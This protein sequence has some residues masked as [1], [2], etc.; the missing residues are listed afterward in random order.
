MPYITKGKCVYKKDTGK[1]VGC[2]KGSVKKYLAALHANVNESEDL[3]WAQDLTSHPSIIDGLLSFKGK[4]V[5]IDISDLDGDQMKQLYD[6]LLPYVKVGGYDGP[7]LWWDNRCFK[8][9]TFRDSHTEVISL[10]CGIEDNG[11]KPVNGLVCCLPTMEDALGTLEEGDYI[12]IDG[13]MLLPPKNMNESEED[14]DWVPKLDPRE[15]VTFLP[16]IGTRVEV[17]T[18]DGVTGEKETIRGEVIGVYPE[19]SEEPGPFFTMMID[20]G[21]Q[22][23]W[24]WPCDSEKEFR[25]PHKAHDS[26]CW[27]VYPKHG[28]NVRILG[29]NINESEEEFDWVPREVDLNNSD[30]LF[31][32]IEDVLKNS[33]FKIV[34]DDDTYQI[35][36]EYGDT[37]IY[38][39]EKDFNLPFIYHDIKDNLVFLNAEEDNDLIP[40]YKRLL[41]LIRPLYNDNKDILFKP[42]NESEEDHSFV[43]SDSDFGWAQDAIAGLEH[44]EN[45]DGGELPDGTF[46]IINGSWDGINFYDQEAKIVRRASDGYLLVFPKILETFN[47]QTTHCGNPEEYETDEYNCH[48]VDSGPNYPLGGGWDGNSDGRCWFVELGELS[49]VKVFP[50]R[51]GFLGESEEFDWVNDYTKYLNVGQKFKVKRKGVEGE[52]FI[53]QIISK[54]HNNV[55]ISPLDMV[56]KGYPGTPLTIHRLLKLM[57]NGHWTPI[58]DIVESRENKPLLTEGRY[59]AITRKVVRD[60]MNVVIQTRGKNDELHQASLPNAFREDE[61]EYSQEGLSFGVELNVHHQNIYETKAADKESDAYYVHTAIAD[62]DE[63]IIMMTVVVDPAWEPR[64]YERLFYKLQEDIRHEIEHFTQ[65]GPNRISDRPKSKT[66]T[67]NLKTTYGHHKNKI[68]VPAL[69]HG[70]YRRAKLEGK[71]LDDIMVD[72]LDSEIERGNL[73]SK[74]AQKL[75]QIWLDYAKKNL[76]HAQY[77]GEY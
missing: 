22:A 36:D 26:H 58:E 41:S 21:W 16:P 23:E 66:D 8:R 59:D 34:K 42:I 44:Y 75:L 24:G 5:V 12:Q 69:V 68:E 33:N 74:Q 53:A 35:E 48:C 71:P 40:Y 1:K 3:E 51:K 2:T 77:S 46:L 72:D 52:D 30:V 57:V 18:E 64:I 67:A 43:H 29:V 45:W 54:A 4:E 32:V 55:W 70:F 37:Y 25:E 49:D 60:I 65:M 15:N 73:T 9:E 38:V 14:F 17:D 47:D 39:S 11:F 10:H 62:D 19:E 76:P 56:S 63:N 28:D 31:N 50:N 20:G 6:V 13:K 7:D 27:Y 61:Y